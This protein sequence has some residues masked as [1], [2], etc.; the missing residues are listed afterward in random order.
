MQ[1]IIVAS[2][3]LLILAVQQ[4]AA[5]KCYVCNSHKD[6]NCALDTPP[7]NLIMDCQEDYS[8]RGKGI[9]TYCRKI[10]Q[11]IEFSVNNLPPD[12]RVIRTCGFQ[13]QTSIN[14]CYQRAGFGGRQ[15]VCSC[16]KDNCNGASALSVAMATSIFCGAALLLKHFLV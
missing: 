10:T 14:Y 2:A 5:I 13:N 1:S 12:S 15:V 11:I 3:L 8:T 6:L 4:G 16:D 7:D 9:P